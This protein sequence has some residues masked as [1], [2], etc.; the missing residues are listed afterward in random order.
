MSRIGLA[1]IAVLLLASMIPF[2]FVARSRATKSPTPALNPVADMDIQSKQKPQSASIL[3]AD[4]RAMRP[5]VQGTVAR[6]DLFVETEILNDP[7]DPRLVD[8]NDAAIALSNPVLHAAITLGRT[9]S[10]GTTDEQ[11]NK[12]KPVN[13]TNPKASDDDIA[14]DTFYV[15][16]IPSQIKVTADFIHRGQE[17]F[18]IYCA[19][20]HGQSAYG[21]GPVAAHAKAIQEA[22]APGRDAV[23][24]VPQDL[25][26]AKIHTRPDGHIFNTIT[27]GVRTMPPYDKQISILDRWA[28]VAYVR[29]VQTSQNAPSEL[30]N[31]PVPSKP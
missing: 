21:D 17:R 20:C 19:P 26:A 5:Q 1:V 29:A 15:K 4:K 18:N 7:A 25:N 14:T 16:T 13:I 11:F 28:I 8:K 2:A 22:G 24:T 27:N 3:F 9:R 23:W 6:E 31:S 12:A 30:A 10:E